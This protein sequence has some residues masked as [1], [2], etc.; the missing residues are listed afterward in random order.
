M[1]RRDV[2]R[3]GLVLGVS[4]LLG[5]RLAVAAGATV[6]PAHS[7]F[8]EV[9]PFAID[10]KKVWAFFDFE[11]QN[12]RDLHVTLAN[13]GA[14]LPKGRMAMEFSPIVTMEPRKV[15]AVRG[16]EAAKRIATPQQLNRLMEGVYN[17]VQTHGRTL[18]NAETW[19]SALKYAGIS[20][21][22]FIEQWGRVTS[23]DVDRYARRM[24]E[25]NVRATP[26]LGIG[27]RFV[28]TPD[29]ANGNM[30]MFIDLANGLTS[31]AMAG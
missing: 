21:A 13:W 5:P 27:G 19:R 9:G 29:N 10:R 15:A 25:Y 8:S 17:L 28:I 16:F 18:D 20:E 22:A 4:A 14:S 24:V 6:P 26:A 23:A 31:K 12:C 2:L 1:L 11:C 30:R 7:P 3:N